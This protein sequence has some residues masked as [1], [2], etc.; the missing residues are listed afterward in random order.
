MNNTTKQDKIA[1][2]EQQVQ[3]AIQQV[4]EQNII[5]CILWYSQGKVF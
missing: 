1:G 3:E 2:L 4:G 5:G